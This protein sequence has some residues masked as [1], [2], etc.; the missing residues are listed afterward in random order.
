[1]GQPDGSPWVLSSNATQFDK[2]GNLIEQKD[3]LGLFSSSGFGYGGN[4]VKFV[5][6]NSRFDE[7]GFD[8]FEDYY[9]YKCPTDDGFTF[10]YSIDE[11]DLDQLIDENKSHSGRSSLKLN[12]GQSLEMSV[13]LE[14]CED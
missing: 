11:D 2:N 1:M 9:F 6:G 3:A 4:L 7:S 5:S 8:S 13:P 10:Y 12:T 14:N